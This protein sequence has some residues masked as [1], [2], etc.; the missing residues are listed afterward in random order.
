MSA[1]IPIIIIGLLFVGGYY[2]RKNRPKMPHTHELFEVNGQMV[3]CTKQEAREFKFLE[4]LRRT[5]VRNKS[6]YKK[7]KPRKF[8][9]G[10]YKR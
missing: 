1:I 10:T 8:Q 2:K 9:L 3:M 5:V 6:A 4:E 7:M